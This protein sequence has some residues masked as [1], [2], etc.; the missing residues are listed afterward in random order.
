MPHPEKA[1]Q[2]I[3]HARAHIRGAKAQTTGERCLPVEVLGLRYLCYVQ[4][5]WYGRESFGGQY[6]ALY[7]CSDTDRPLHWCEFSAS[8]HRWREA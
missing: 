1:V 4:R 2:F 6:G 7:T 3:W 8:V 5:G